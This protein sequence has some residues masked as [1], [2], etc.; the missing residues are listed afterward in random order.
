[1]VTFLSDCHIWVYDKDSKLCILT[2]SKSK[3]KASNYLTCY[4]SPKPDYQPPTLT[5]ADINTGKYFSTAIDD[6]DPE[7]ISE[8]DN[9][10][11]PYEKRDIF[12]DLTHITGHNSTSDWQLKINQGRKISNHNVPS[13]PSTP[14]PGSPRYVALTTTPTLRRSTPQT[15]ISDAPLSN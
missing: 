12:P 4:S 7:P 13:L 14:P 2:K 15:L 9:E 5:I 10:D 8:D 11:D 3:S 6:F 1:M